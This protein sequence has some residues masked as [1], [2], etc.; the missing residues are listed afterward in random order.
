MNARRSYFRCKHKYEQLCPATRQVQQSE[1]DPSM[2]EITYIGDH[3]CTQN[4]Q[5]V[6]DN[7]IIKREDVLSPST[8]FES[9]RAHRAPA[10][11][12]STHG[13]DGAEI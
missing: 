2:F 12:E 8:E 13:G 3:T 6:T 9:G 7:G 11:H 1:A 5:A 4:R 10:D